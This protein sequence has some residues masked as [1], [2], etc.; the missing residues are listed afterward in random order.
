MH[1]LR[2][3]LGAVG[4][5]IDRHG[6]I[7]ALLVTAA[8]SLACFRSRPFSPTEFLEVAI[9]RRAQFT[10]GW[11]QEVIGG[12]LHGPF[13]PLFAYVL[14][15]LAVDHEFPHRLLS[16]ASLLLAV[17]AWYR[18]SREILDRRSALIAALFVGSSY[19]GL[20]VSHE[21]TRY[22]LHLALGLLCVGWLLR[23]LHSTDRRAC[24]ALG[25]LVFLALLNHMIIG[26][27]L[28]AWVPLWLVSFRSARQRWWPPIAAAAGALATLP[29]TFKL[30]VGAEEDPGLPPV[31]LELLHELWEMFEGGLLLPLL[32]GVLLLRWLRDRLPPWRQLRFEGDWPGVGLAHL[33]LWLVP[34]AAF[35]LISQFVVTL[36]YPDY[37][38][39]AL[40]SL[41]VLY[42]A[43]H[44]GAGPIAR[45]VMLVALL[46]NGGLN[47]A[48]RIQ[49]TP[50]PGK[51]LFGQIVTVLDLLED[52]STEIRV[53]PE[54][55]RPGV[56]FYHR[57]LGRGDLRIFDGF[58]EQMPYPERLCL[59]GSRM[60]GPSV[61]RGYLRWRSVR[62]AL[63][64][65][66][67]HERVRPTVGALWVICYQDKY[68]H[69][70]PRSPGGP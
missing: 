24:L 39:P 59:V 42:G 35:L 33:L 2:H 30:I 34:I 44:A 5:W 22:A 28:L 65:V 32:I 45:A 68:R 11:L 26:L 56:R 48:E 25:G 14:D 60:V 49:S 1:D 8:A 9:G 63:R 52:R 47:V 12:E 64:S 10:W 15:R 46:V 16:L 20:T 61:A 53:L 7:V 18:A 27:L 58:G 13:Y 17:G 66:Y 69:A 54:W 23:C 62:G 19:H 57:R 70:A 50:D 38:L 40:G 6:L 67:R 41:G 51:T 21:F 55:D 29:F 31:S 3:K 37:L 36:T 4:A 43:F